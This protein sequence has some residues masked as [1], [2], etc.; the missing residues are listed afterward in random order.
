MSDGRLAGLL[1]DLSGRT[2]R[3]LVALVVEQLAATARGVRL[4]HAAT[5]GDITAAQARTRMT[6]VEHDG[7]DRRAALVLRMQASITSPIDREDLFR[8]SRSVDDVLD[9]LRDFVRELDLF[10]A[11]PQ[12]SYSAILQA[13]TTSVDHFTEAVHLLAAAPRQAA[14]Q[15]LQAKKPGVRL[16]YQLA[17]A[18]LL[19]QPLTAETLKATL[20]LGR[21]D[22][23]GVSLAGAADALADGVVKRFQ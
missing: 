12:P 4:A 17:L 9:A 13:L 19:N 7:D 15:A 3:V 11:A 1:R 16:H 23:A 18:E 2:D 6:V 5:S 20:L 22:A 21:L 10:D 8:L 14:Q